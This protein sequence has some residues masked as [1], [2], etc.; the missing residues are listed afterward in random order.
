MSEALYERNPCFDKMRVKCPHCQHPL[1]VIE[2]LS[3]TAE[4][5]WLSG[6]LCECENPKCFAKQ[7]RYCPGEKDGKKSAVQG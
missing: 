3:P 2:E 6:F 7:L 1:K 5:P 4:E